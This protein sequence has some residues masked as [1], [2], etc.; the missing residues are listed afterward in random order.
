MNTD[1]HIERQININT[2]LYMEHLLFVA[3]MMSLYFVCLL[4]PLRL[5]IHVVTFLYLYVAVT[6]AAY[7]AVTVAAY[8]VGTVVVAVVDTV[9]NAVVDLYV[10]YLDSSVIVMIAILIMVVIDYITY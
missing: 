6:V 7:V 9:D 1:I 5:E 2:Q 8:V 4:I 10:Y 3:M